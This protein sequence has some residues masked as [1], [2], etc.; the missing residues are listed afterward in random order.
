MGINGINIYRITPTSKLERV[1]NK[2]HVNNSLY[3][4][5]QQ[6]QS[7]SDKKDNHRSF[8]EI[9]REEIKKNR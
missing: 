4:D 8:D 3:R 7:E 9:F 2:G 1:K 6:K 5:N